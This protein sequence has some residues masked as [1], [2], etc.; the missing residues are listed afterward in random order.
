[1]VKI[2]KVKVPLYPVDI[3]FCSDAKML[4]KKFELEHWGS[5]FGGYCWS[6]ENSQF[7]AIH[8]PH[9]N[10][11]LVLPHLVHECFHAAMF[12]ADIVG[13][14]PTHRKNES[15]AYLASWI[16]ETILDIVDKESRSQEKK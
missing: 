16:S 5:E 10:G 2:H 8:L 14:D 13:L 6:P 11:S 3:Y 7:V 4:D 1:V 9:E 12:V 15:A